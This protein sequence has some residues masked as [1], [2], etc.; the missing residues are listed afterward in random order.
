MNAPLQH[1]LLEDEPIVELR[2]P[3]RT[4]TQLLA[5]IIAGRSILT[6]RSNRS[7]DR[8]TFR[9]RR[10]DPEPGKKRPIWVSILGG[11]EGGFTR[12]QDEHG[13]VVELAPRAWSFL[14]TIWPED[15]RAWTFRHSHKSKI[16][17]DAPVVKAATWIG[18]MIPFSVDH[19]MEEAEWWHEGRC[20]RCGRRLTVPESI[21]SG[22]GPE[23]IKHVEAS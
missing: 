8:L 23:C 15:G 9:F 13:P 3:I 10:P 12:S 18:R 2:R 4:P 14:G 22:F 11:P 7:Q 19:L 21:E 20:G 1:V 17:T 5:M 16:A 6:V